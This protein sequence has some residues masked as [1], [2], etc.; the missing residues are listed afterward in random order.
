M[1]VIPS[2]HT[3]IVITAE[4]ETP[5]R[6]TLEAFLHGTDRLQPEVLRIQRLPI[7]EDAKPGCN[8]KWIA[9]QGVM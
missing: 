5:S 4:S 1:F 2:C 8:E 6:N 7:T 3:S 9:G